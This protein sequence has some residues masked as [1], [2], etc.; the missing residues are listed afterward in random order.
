MLDIKVKKTTIEL[1][2]AT[3]ISP[4]KIS[5]IILSKMLVQLNSTACRNQFVKNVTGAQPGFFSGLER[6]LGIRAI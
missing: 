4:N 3:D 2:T 1:V 6:F 5:V